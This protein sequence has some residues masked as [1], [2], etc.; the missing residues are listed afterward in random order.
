M[1]GTGRDHQNE[2]NLLAARESAGKSTLAAAWSARETA[3]GGTV[4][5]IGTEESREHAQVPRLIAAGADME[6]VVF[7]D[8]ATS[9]AAAMLGAL[10]FPLDLKNVEKVIRQHGV[11]MIVLDPCKG[12]VP[13]VSRATMTLPSASTSNPSGRCATAPA[14]P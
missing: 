12:L 5:W 4:L 7:V 9:G 3:A 8:V 6:R 2:I 11:T 10:Q 1:V 14:P 13:P